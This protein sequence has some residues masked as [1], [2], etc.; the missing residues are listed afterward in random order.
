MKLIREV[1]C[2]KCGKKQIKDI[3]ELLVADL[4][5]RT[6]EFCNRYGLYR[7]SR[8]KLTSVREWLMAL[9][10]AMDLQWVEKAISSGKEE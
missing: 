1:I 9:Y 5:W 2:S 8:W 10:Q 4:F 3:K 6:C 7:V